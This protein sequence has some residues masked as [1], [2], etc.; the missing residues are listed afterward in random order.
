MDKLPPSFFFFIYF[1]CG[2]FLQRVGGNI[3]Y[4][5]TFFIFSLIFIKKKYSFL[6]PLFIFFLLLGYFLSKSSIPEF[7]YFTGFKIE[8]VKGVVEDIEEREKIK[9][10][11]F[12]PFNEREKILLIINKDF[13]IDI[14]EILLIEELEVFPIE[15]EKVYKFWEKD[16]ILWGKIKYFRILGENKSFFDLLRIK[17]KNYIK[18]LLSLSSPI[19]SSFLKAVILGESGVLAKNVKD[20]FINTGTA[21]ILA[22]SGFHITL[23]IS[24]LTFFLNSKRLKLILSLVLFFYAFIIGNKPPVLRA[25]GMYFFNILAKIFLR[26]EDSINSFFY[27]CLISLIFSPLNLFNIS[28]Q[29]SYFATLGLILTPS[30]K[31]PFITK[32]YQDLWRSSLWLFIFLLPFNIYFFGRIPI[33]SFIGNLFVIP[34]FQII[35]FLSFLFIFLGIFPVSS[36]LLSIIEFFLNILLSG[37]QFILINYK[38]SL[39]LSLILILSPFIWK[40]TRNELL[41]I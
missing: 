32:Y 23:L 39:I 6:I 37:L 12:K 38:I 40:N 24:F 17:A 35:L 28:F 7:S 27:V 15:G 1:F 10:V 19:V 5:L 33:L 20:L 36:F 4:L 3:F 25:V 9:E 31:I 41:G 30:L 21:H 16:V 14:G 2:I 18:N 26:E 22:I 8:K 29:L 11:I 34:I 13:K